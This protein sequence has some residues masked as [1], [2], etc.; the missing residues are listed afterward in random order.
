MAR[1]LARAPWGLFHGI[2]QLSICLWESRRD[3]GHCFWVPWLL[4]K[5]LHPQLPRSSCLPSCLTFQNIR[6]E[7]VLPPEFFEVL[8]SSQNGSHH[9]IRAISKGQTAI[10]AALTSVVDQAS[11][12]LPSSKPLA[13]DLRSIPPRAGLQGPQLTW[14]YFSALGAVLFPEARPSSSC[15]PPCAS[16]EWKPLFGRGVWF[17][18]V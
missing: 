6:I 2:A 11:E 18:C 1:G 15:P 17:L 10:N 13:L 14:L 8:S 7:A 3:P 5:F 16:L 9:H 4:A 12:L